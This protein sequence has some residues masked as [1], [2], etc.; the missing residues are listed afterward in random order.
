MTQT[1]LINA[2][3]EIETSL[4]NVGAHAPERSY[5]ERALHDINTVINKCD[6]CKKACTPEPGY[7]NDILEA[8]G[9]Y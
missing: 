9:K 8:T 7:V 1:N 6:K 5:L 3:Y 2:R 4:K